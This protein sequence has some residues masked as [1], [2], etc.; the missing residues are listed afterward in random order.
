MN[1]IYSRKTKLVAYM[2]ISRL[3]SS[4]SLFR[5]RIFLPSSNPLLNPYNKDQPYIALLN[6]TIIF[7]IIFCSAQNHSIKTHQ[8]K[9]L[10]FL[11]KFSASSLSK[12]TIS[13]FLLKKPRVLIH[14]LPLPHRLVLQISP[15]AT[16][17]SIQN[18]NFIN[19]YSV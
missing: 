8:P 19:M 5:E 11:F 3:I 13:F 6:D 2:L 10:P 16:Q 14:I 9:T 17:L 18:T 12:R 7:R 1:T 15:R 4:L